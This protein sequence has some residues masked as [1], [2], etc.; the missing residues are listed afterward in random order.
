MNWFCLWETEFT[1]QPAAYIFGQM[2]FLQHLATA[3]KL[4]LKWSIPGRISSTRDLYFQDIHMSYVYIYIFIYTYML[5][6]SDVYLYFTRYALLFTDKAWFA[7][8]PRIHISRKMK[9]EVYGFFSAPVG[10][11]SWFVSLLR[12]GAAQDPLGN[13]AFQ[14][15]C[16][17]R[18][19]FQSLGANAER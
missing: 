17:L 8:F 19:W 10:S 5:H 11:W 18:C 12:S 14:T 15:P 1:L 6:I 3:L 9:A 7:I 13:P 2:P 16:P 4:K